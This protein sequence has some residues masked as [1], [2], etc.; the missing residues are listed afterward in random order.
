[1]LTKEERAKHWS[2]GAED[3]DWYIK[4]ELN[5]F[6]EENWYKL[7]IDK[8]D[9]KEKLKVLDCGC[10]PGFFSVVLSKRGHDVTGIDQAEGMLEK[11]AEHAKEAGVEPEFKKMFLQEIEFPDNTFD[12]VLSRNVTWNLSNPEIVYA[13]WKRVLK[14]GGTLIIFDSTW[15]KSLFD[16]E[17]KAE[18]ERRRKEYEEKYEKLRGHDSDTRPSHDH[19]DP[20]T[21]PLSNVDRPDWDIEELKK[22]GFS[23]CFV[24]Y[25]ISETIWDDGE[26]LLH[27]ATPMFMVGGI[28]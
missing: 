6:R 21:L 17:L 28:K 15:Y 7:I 2:N 19:V 5:S 16:D 11:A 20:K 23:E 22:Q 26:K 10:G 4:R 27:G 13:E 18:V 25:D 1:M 14:P 8:C 3:Y 24:E 12:L 9:K